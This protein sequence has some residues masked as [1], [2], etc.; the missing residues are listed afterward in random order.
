MTS[1]KSTMVFVLA[2]IVVLTLSGMVYAESYNRVVAVVND[3]VITLHELNMKMKEMTG[4][5]DEEMK[6]RNLEKYLNT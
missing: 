3:D 4:M 1:I 6:N 5:S 2:I